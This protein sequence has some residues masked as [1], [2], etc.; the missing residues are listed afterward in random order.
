MNVR[1]RHVHRIALRVLD[2][3]CQYLRTLPVRRQRTVER[4]KG[5]GLL[6]D[7]RG[8][9]ADLRLARTGAIAPSVHRHTADGVVVH[10]LSELVVRQH[11][12]VRQ[13]AVL[14]DF[15]ASRQQC[16]RRPVD[17]VHAVAAVDGYAQGF[18]LPR[19][20]GDQRCRTQA[21]SLFLAVFQDNVVV[22]LNQVMPAAS[23]AAHRLHRIR[24][25]LLLPR[26]AQLITHFHAKAGIVLAA[27]ALALLGAE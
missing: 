10:P 14:H 20:A 11:H 4:R 17:A 25:D 27:L 18:F 23:Q 22:A 1:L 3:Q 16:W 6:I 21:D 13:R 5:T 26:H 12:A 24:V 15:A 9:H 7:I 8:V 19:V 2:A